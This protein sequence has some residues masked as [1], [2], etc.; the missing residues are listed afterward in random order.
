MHIGFLTDGLAGLPLDQVIDTVVGLGLREIEIPTG[1]WSDAPHLDL[2]AMIASQDRRDELTGML[3]D[4]GVRLGA[5]NINGNVLSP[6]NGAEQAGNARN[7][8]LLAEQL[9]ITKIVTMSGLPPVFPGDRVA[10]WIVTCWPAEN[11][12]NR[13]RQWQTTV[14]FWKEFAPFAADHGIE[15]IAL[16]MHADQMIW[17]PPTLLHLR[18]EIGEIIGANMDPSH[19]MWM[20]ADPLAC[21]EYLDGAI[22]HVHAKDT[23]IEDLAR[24]RTRLEPLFFDR[25]DERAWNYVTLG[26]GHPGGVEY[27]RQFCTALRRSGYDGVLSIEHEDVAYAPEAGLAK[28][29]DVLKEAIA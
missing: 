8:V 17:N 22:Y 24:V 12:P 13:E 4:K 20:G 3:A 19:L 15:R 18:E 14:G 28:A 26:E 23:R 10:P 16:E 21:I 5:L 9:G 11:V 7:T 27:W 6:V 25:R 1:N 2:D 29:V